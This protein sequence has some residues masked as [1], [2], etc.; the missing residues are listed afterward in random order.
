MNSFGEILLRKLKENLFFNKGKNKAVILAYHRVLKNSDAM[1]GGIINS[2]AFD[3]QME[4]LSK[5]FNV[6]KLSEVSGYI[7][8]NSLPDYSVCITFDD[9][10][11][12][13]F[14]VALPILK[15]WN[16]PATFFIATGFLD[17]GIMWNDSITESI[18]TFPGKR[19]DLRS[20]GLGVYDISDSSRYKISREIVL[21]VKYFPYDK[22]QK[23]VSTL[24]KKSG[25]DVPNN[26]MMSSEQVK[27]LV[28][29]GMD[30]GAHTINHPILSKIPLEDA[31][32]EIVESKKILAHLTNTEV[33]LFAYPN[34]RPESDYTQE[35]VNI[36]QQQGF[37]AAVSTN[38]NTVTSASNLFELPRMG[39]L[40]SNQYKFYYHMINSFS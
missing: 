10:Y 34:G 3:K 22:R 7:R 40:D 39:Y 28:D 31:S 11:A 13:N 6:I 38:W 35:H 30:V 33:D 17:G 14:E 15:K 36:I 19:L 2:Y 12:D 5:L 23:L 24:I 20:S 29:S 37:K 8:N 26:I 1:H 25:I 18:R 16:L 27:G 4:V 32:N 9:G 21:S